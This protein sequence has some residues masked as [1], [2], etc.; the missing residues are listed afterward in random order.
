MGMKPR[1]KA[2]SPEWRAV[3]RRFA[4]DLQAAVKRH[5]TLHQYPRDEQSPEERLLARCH[6]TFPA[7]NLA[8]IILP[9]HAQLFAD[10]LAL[11]GESELTWMHPYVQAAGNQLVVEVLLVDNADEIVKGEIDAQG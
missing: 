2:Y 6:L 11:F 4:Q 7:V 1:K 5:A 8:K 9:P 3:H 10:T